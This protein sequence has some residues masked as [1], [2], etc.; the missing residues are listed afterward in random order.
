MTDA[1]D[2]DSHRFPEWLTG[3]GV[4]PQLKWRFGTDGTL[5]ALA[6]SRES[7][8][9]FVADA[10]GTLYRLDRQG[11][12]AA[13]TRMHDPLIELVWSDDGR[14]GAGLFGED[15][16]IRF[17]RNLKTI[18]KI[19]LPDVGVA[20]AISPF[21][22]HLAVGLSG[23]VNLIFNERK[24]R[25]AKFETIRPLTFLQ[26][27]STET[28]LIGAA[29]HGLL[30]AHNLQGAEIWQEK[31]WSNVGRL[32]I[33]GDSD[34]IYL[35]SFAHGIQTLDGDGASIGSYVVDGTANRLDVSFEPHRLIVSTIERSLFWLDADGE[36]IWT[37]SVDD[38]IVD[39]ACDPLGVGALIGFHEKGLVR[40]DWNDA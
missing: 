9:A 11:R 17:D 34:L 13:L 29:E 12:I 25:I 26:F 27:C 20:L 4:G 18:H 15:I 23:G 35:A 3:R 33:T 19:S 32:K 40:L 7:G 36:L 16:V 37:T 38:D 28:V 10:T 5:T 39:L 14:W 31:N 24:R 30:C 6:T 1:R 8:D 21:G 2:P 22:N